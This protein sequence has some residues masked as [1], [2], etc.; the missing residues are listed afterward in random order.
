VHTSTKNTTRCNAEICVLYL[1]TACS[2]AASVGLSI[3]QCV[4]GEESGIDEALMPKPAGSPTA[5]PRASA[6][7]SFNAVAGK[8]MR[9]AHAKAIVSG[10][11]GFE[12]FQAH[13]R[14]RK[15]VYDAMQ[16]V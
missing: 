6:T 3:V 4:L 7:R 9:M 5:Q 16:R 14:G 13:V 1:C 15:A 8:G 12:L 11:T 2:C 10:N